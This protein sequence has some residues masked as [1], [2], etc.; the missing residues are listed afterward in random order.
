MATLLLKLVPF[1]TVGLVIGATVLQGLLVND[2]FN[3][4]T[5]TAAD[6]T[7]GIF[8]MIILSIATLFILLMAVY[9]SSLLT[10]AVRASTPWIAIL[11]LLAATILQGFLVADIYK[12][13]SSTDKGYGTTN[14]ILLIIASIFA[15]IFT[16]EYIAKG[17][18]ALLGGLL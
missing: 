2:L 15:L 18:K 5:A 4:G 6:K 9:Y 13:N 12:G 11:G 17:K 1:V 10:R 14:L 7:Y 16:V 8:V 3:N